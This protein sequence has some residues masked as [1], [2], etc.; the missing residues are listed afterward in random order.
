MKKKKT[1][2]S[3]V[4]PIVIQERVEKHMIEVVRHAYLKQ[5]W[6]NLNFAG[7]DSVNVQFLRYEI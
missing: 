7:S 2:A 5:E 6:G 3:K 1:L 4:G